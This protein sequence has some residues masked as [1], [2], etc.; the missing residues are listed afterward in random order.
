MNK[1]FKNL[2]KELDE[3]KIKPMY[4]HVLKG[5]VVASGSASNMR[6]LVK[7]NGKTVDKG[8]NSNYVLN[9]PG[10]KI[11]D[12]EELGGAYSYAYM[13]QHPVVDLNAAKFSN[14]MINKLKK[15]YEPLK[16]KK[17][18]PT[19]LMKTFDKID[20]NKDGLIQLYK[21]DIPFVSMMA[22][23]R[24]MLKHNYKASDINKLGKIRREDFVDE[25][26]ASDAQRK[27]AFASG[28]K[29]KGKKKK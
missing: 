26:F 28:Y 25:K 29:A 12:I 23:S 27:A 22:M 3:R 24:L 11:G 17:V 10:A 7:K 13:D 21:A 8:P 4:H 5:K 18:N 16:G 1:T 15:T 2:V 20:K 19:P 9:S 6:K 14:D